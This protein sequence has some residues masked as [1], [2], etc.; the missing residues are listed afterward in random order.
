MR[1]IFRYEY[2]RHIIIESNVYSLRNC[3]N[4][5][6]I[7]KYN[8]KHAALS[9][10]LG[11]HSVKDHYLHRMTVS[12][13]GSP[14]GHWNQIHWIWIL[15]PDSMW[16][17]VS[18]TWHADYA[19]CTGGSHGTVLEHCHAEQHAAQIQIEAVWSQSGPWIQIPDPH[20]I[21]IQGPVWRVLIW[22]VKMCICS[23]FVKHHTKQC[24]YY[25]LLW[26][27]TYIFIIC[28]SQF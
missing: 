12:G 20:Q 23:I 17:H 16:S 25:E 4:E 10:Q 2:H 27:D 14:H 22:E 13:W 19:H 28:F 21:R 3:K 18:S 5:S 8:M 7:K 1:V 24:L 11:T 26:P 6:S 9:I 15:N